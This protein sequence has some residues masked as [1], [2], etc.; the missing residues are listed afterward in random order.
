VHAVVHWHFD[1]TG[2]AVPDELIAVA[3]FANRMEAELAQG[4]LAAQDIESV[5]SADDIG[6]QYPGIWATGIRLL[7]RAS[8]VRRAQAVLQDLGESDPETGT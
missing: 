7:V 8:A 5:I 3:A 4:A 6:G 2:G 1:N